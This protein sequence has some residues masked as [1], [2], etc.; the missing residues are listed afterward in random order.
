MRGPGL[1]QV[2]DPV[3]I[4][5]SVTAAYWPAACPGPAATQSA[6]LLRLPG[7]TDRER[8]AGVVLAEPVK[9]PTTVD[10]TGVDPTTGSRIGFL[11]VGPPQVLLVPRPSRRHYA[12][13]S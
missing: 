9:G 12:C 8:P 3:V 13:Y 7:R 2:A 5:V 1:A 10:P 6:A 11:R 4:C